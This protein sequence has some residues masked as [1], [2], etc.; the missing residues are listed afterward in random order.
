M[1]R[2][3]ASNEACVSATAIAK[4]ALVIDFSI[5]IVRSNVDKVAPH[6]N[7]GCLLQK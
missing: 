5:V 2:H 7:Q 6:G 3:S 4:N 1:K